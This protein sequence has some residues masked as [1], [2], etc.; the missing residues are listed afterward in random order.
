MNEQER[1]EA[2]WQE[3][4]QRVEARWQREREEE[5]ELSADL[6]RERQA[7][8]QEWSDQVDRDE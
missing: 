7:D 2:Y 5:D 4:A 6:Y 1:L 3:I 8:L